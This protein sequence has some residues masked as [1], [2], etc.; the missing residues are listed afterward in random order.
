M[1][2]AFKSTTFTHD[3]KPFVLTTPG[4]FHETGDFRDRGPKTHYVDDEVDPE[5]IFET[6]DLMIPMTEQ[7][8]GLLGSP[9]FIPDDGKTYAHNPS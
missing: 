1:G 4:H 8:P 6:G 3:P 2:Y 9:A 5:F 7:A